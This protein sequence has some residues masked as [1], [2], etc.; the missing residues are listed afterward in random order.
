M[1]EAAAHGSSQHSVRANVTIART[2]PGRAKVLRRPLTGFGVREVVHCRVRDDGVEAAQRDDVGEHVT[3]EPGHRYVGKT[4]LVPDPEPVVRGQGPRR[5]IPG[6][7]A[8][9]P[10]SRRRSLLREH[11]CTLD[12]T[13]ASNVPS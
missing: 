1:K 5:A 12:G 2:P 9:R 11:F 8:V 6:A 3:V 4:A 10:E 13:S 7:P